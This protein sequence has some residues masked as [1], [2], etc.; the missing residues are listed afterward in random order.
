MCV[1]EVGGG[2]LYIL[3]SS[4][5][6]SF[7][8]FHK[9]PSQTKLTH[10]QNVFRAVVLWLCY[11]ETLL[12]QPSCHAHASRYVLHICCNRAV[13]TPYKHMLLQG[14]SS[15]EQLVLGL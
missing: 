6:A 4:V 8:H 9:K 12:K 13:G 1:G 15:F 7:K 3:E 5:T 10:Y 14:R 2:S 11:T